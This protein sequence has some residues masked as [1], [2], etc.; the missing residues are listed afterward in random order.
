MRFLQRIFTCRVVRCNAQLQEQYIRYQPRPLTAAD[1]VAFSESGDSVKSFHFIREELPTRWMQMLAEMQLLPVKPTP[2]M[3]EIKNSFEQSVNEILPFT[4]MDSNPETISKY[5]KILENAVQ[6]HKYVVDEVAIAILEFKEI[7]KSDGSES[8]FE[9]AEG[10]IHYFLDRFFTNIIAGS[11]VVH[12]H[13]HHLSDLQTAGRYGRGTFQK[14]NVTEEISEMGKKAIID[15]KKYYGKSPLVNITNVDGE[16]TPESIWMTFVPDHLNRIVFELLRNALRATVEKN[17]ELPPVD[18][19]ISKG[20]SNVCIKISDLGGGASLKDQAKWGAYLYSSPP[21]ESK[22]KEANVMPL[23]GYGYG[24][25]LS[26]V[27]ARYIGGD[28]NIRSIQNYGTDV[29][30]YLP[31]EPDQLVEFLPI[32]SSNTEA[33]YKEKKHKSTWVSGK[34]SEIRFETKP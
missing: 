34:D 9:K 13:L 17:A 11:L 27:Y 2:I 15:C 5:N 7:Q 23:A 4:K 6:R 8:K 18:V 33:Y 24:I 14:T 19:L 28:V 31:A 32:F 22:S 10:R 25:P 21:K 1:F 12:Q 20:E 30:V 3:L 16:K 26:K 29:Y